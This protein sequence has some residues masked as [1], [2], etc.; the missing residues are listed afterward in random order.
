MASLC[1]VEFAGE[2]GDASLKRKRRMRTMRWVKAQSFACASGF[3]GCAVP[4]EAKTAER[5]LNSPAK[6]AMQA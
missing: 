4:N 5:K 6:P 2:A 3:I 1:K